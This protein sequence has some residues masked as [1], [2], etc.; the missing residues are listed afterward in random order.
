MPELPPYT[1]PNNVSISPKK[2][3]KIWIPITIGVGIF[4]LVLITAIILF[5]RFFN[6]LGSQIRDTMES[7]I[8][9][10]DSSPNEDAWDDSETYIDDAEVNEENEYVI[11]YSY[12]ELPFN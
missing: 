2:K 10:D 3:S 8:T 4:L 5:N 11:T 12:A 7:Q 6:R 9:I 1:A